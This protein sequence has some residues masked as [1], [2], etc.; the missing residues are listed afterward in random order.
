MKNFGALVIKF[1]ILSSVSNYAF[2]SKLDLATHNSL[3][4]KL[5]SASG[6]GWSDAMLL[7]T[8]MAYRLAGLYAERAR[9]LSMDEEGRGEQIH[10]KKIAADRAKSVSILNKVLKSLDKETRG[11][12]LLQIAHLHIL[13]GQP[14]QALAIFAQIEKSPAQYDGRT[15]ALVEV[16][17]GDVAFSRGELPQAKTHF[18]KALKIKEN[19]R[20]GYCQFRIAWVNYTQGDTALAEK[21]LVQ[22]LKTP[23]NFTSPTGVLEISFQEEVSHDLALF[24]AKN[25]ITDSNLN[26]LSSLSPENSRKKNLIFLASELDRTAQKIAALKVWKMIGSTVIT[27]ADQLE[28][29]IQV[30]R[31]EYDLGHKNGVIDE[32]Q[33]S[34]ALLKNEACVKNDE[35]VVATQNLRRV[36]TDWAKAEER[37]PSAEVLLAFQIYVMSIDDAEIAYWGATAAYN[38]QQF[39]TAFK[40]YDRTILLLQ[41]IQKKSETQKKMFEGSLLGAIEVAELAK[42]PE[43]RLQAYKKYLEVNP[44]GIKSNEVRYLIAHWYYEKNDYA[45]AMT[46]FVAIVNNPKM[47]MELR[48]KSGDLALDSEVLLKNETAIEARALQLAQALPAKKNEYLSVYRKSILNQ[49][50]AILNQAQTATYVSHL[51]KL[52]SIE[53]KNF[54]P[55]E[56]KQVVKNKIEL[57]YRLQDIEI[58]SKNAKLYLTLKPLTVEE[59][60]M[61]MHHLAW[62]AEIRM[63]FKEA[64]SLLYKMKPESKH[65]ADYH[66][67]IATLKEL[68]NENPTAAYENFIALSNNQVKRAFAAYQ[69]VIFSKNPM[70]AYKKYESLLS[71]NQPLLSSAGIFVFEKSNSPQIFK[72]MMA[73]KAVR[74]SFNGQLLSHS[75][76]LKELSTLQS[77][78]SKAKLKGRSD[79]SLKKTLVMRNSMLKKLETLANRAIKQKDTSMQLIYLASVSDENSRLAKEILALPLPRGLKPNERAEYQAQVQT[80]VTPYQTQADAIKQKTKELWQQAIEQNS[81]QVLGETR[82][83]KNKPGSRLA[84]QEVAFLRASAGRLGLA[85]DLFEKISEQQQ[86]TLSEAKSLKEKL[87]AD[88]FNVS[89]LAKLKNLQVTLKSGPMVAYLDSRLSVIK[90]SGS[91][92]KRGKN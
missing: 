53:L 59:R 80:L 65:L 21:Q 74:N 70:K 18:E 27:F 58:L 11:P 13:Q 62:I 42:N 75:V 76:L 79:N 85:T 66:L 64:L 3:I 77:E 90:S 2:A 8:N 71:H 15:L 44:E 48:Q 78:I 68:A 1:L 50:A 82:V 51:K 49:S 7:Q 57:A 52:D 39:A 17:L 9:I 38:R 28:R 61:A 88:P 5:E 34:I 84:E 47:P 91:G 20:R 4:Q 60:L 67:K 83:A 33:R 87:Q 22:L 45:Q 56:A 37:A 32:M 69:I 14:K 86:K 89:D 29:Q 23:Q 24:M 30:T 25:K 92:L 31:I 63:N 41:N 26:A 55:L 54:L 35:C 36:L 12:A 6:V 81:L 72:S 10:A 46:A 43:L 73:R 19:P 16:Q 40:F